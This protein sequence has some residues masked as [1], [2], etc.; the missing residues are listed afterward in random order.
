MGRCA[1][2]GCDSALDPSQIVTRKSL[3]NSQPNPEIFPMSLGCSD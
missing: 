3:E 1:S 2:S